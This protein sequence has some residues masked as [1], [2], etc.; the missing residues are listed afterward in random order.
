VYV[1]NF[2]KEIMKATTL[3]IKALA[4]GKHKVMSLNFRSLYL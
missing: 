1:C 3:K 4:L 2:V